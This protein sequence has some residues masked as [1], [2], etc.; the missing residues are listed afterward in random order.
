MYNDNGIWILICFSQEY[1]TKCCVIGLELWG[2]VWFTSLWGNTE[3][4][5]ILKA[6]SSKPSIWYAITICKLEMWQIHCIH[7]Y[8]LITL[9]FKSWESWDCFKFTIDNWRQLNRWC[10]SIWILTVWDS[11]LSEALGQQK[12]DSE[13]VFRNQIRIFPFISSG[14]GLQQQSNTYTMCFSFFNNKKFQNALDNNVTKTWKFVVVNLLK[15]TLLL[16]TIW[17]VS[18]SFHVAKFQITLQL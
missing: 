4:C 18:N 2:A 6:S 5:V 13:N 16:R 12:P 11:F 15:L 1:E 17:K 14:A 8:P 9:I 10:H 3:K 7:F